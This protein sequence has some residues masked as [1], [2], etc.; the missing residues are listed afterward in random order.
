MQ[1]VAGR[2]TR[3]ADIA[4]DLTALVALPGTDG[5]PGQ[6]TEP[7]RDPEAVLELD[8][9]AVV[10]VVGR[11]TDDAVGGRMHRRATIGGNVET[12][13]ILAGSVDRV[14]AVAEVRRQPAIQRPQ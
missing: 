6:V 1:M 11:Q 14:A 12:G 13:V 9:I 8:A 10:A 7:G 4:D 5:V 2:A 3:R